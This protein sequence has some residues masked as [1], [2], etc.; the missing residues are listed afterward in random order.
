MGIPANYWYDPKTRERRYCTQDDDHQ[1]VGAPHYKKTLGTSPAHLKSTTLGDELKNSGFPTKV[2]SVSLKDRSAILLGGYRADLAL[3]F[4]PKHFTWVSSTFY[5]PSKE[6]PAWVK[7]EN[8]WIERTLRDPLRWEIPKNESPSGLSAP[9]SKALTDSWNGVIGPDF[10]HTIPARSYAA[11]SGPQGVELTK[12]M[13]LQALKSYSLGKGAGPDLLAVSFSGHDYLSHTHGPISREVEELTI[14]EDRA[15]SEIFVEIEKQVP[16]GLEATLISLTADH[17]GAHNP[18]LLQEGRVPS[19]RVSSEDLV[20]EFEPKLVE[21]LGSP[22]P[23]PAWIASVENLSFALDPEAFKKAPEKRIEAENLLKSFLLE[24]PWIV[25]AITRTDAL[26]KRWPPALL[27]KIAAQTFILDRS[28]DVTGVFRPHHFSGGDT[29]TH[30]TH[31]NYDRLVP[32]IIRG[33]GVPAG[34][35]RERVEVIDLVP[36]LAALLG[37]IPPPMAEGKVLFP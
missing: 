33:R 35:R 3:W 13:A 6:L 31:Y 5:L 1:T 12:R 11:L 24:K 17:G 18:A 25:D 15:L 27:G 8:V 34:R 23:A 10:P 21:K 19:A 9:K 26:A 2:V 16:G 36:T 29:V 4:D 22:A 37:I 7:D 14:L 28:G 30:V 32:L 20:K